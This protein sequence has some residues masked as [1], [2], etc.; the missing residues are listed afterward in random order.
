MKKC[1]LVAGLASAVMISPAM[2]V[3]KCVALNSSSTQCS[4][5]SSDGPDWT[6]SCTTNGTKTTI[7]GISICSSTKSTGDYAATRLEYSTNPNEN[8]HCW[9]RMIS[10]AVSRWISYTD[11]YTSAE[12][13]LGDC[14]MLCSNYLAYSDGYRGAF[15]ESMS[16]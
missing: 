13:C 10:P 6:A 15:F 9:C 1:L 8:I 14:S 11:P 12:K 2:A 4:G 3:T 5:Q 7:A 16:D